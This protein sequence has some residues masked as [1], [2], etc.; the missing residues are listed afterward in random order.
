MTVVSQ[1]LAPLHDGIVARLSAQQPE[2][3]FHVSWGAAE[4]GT[5]RSLDEAIRLADQ[6]MYDTRRAEQA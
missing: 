3:R 4:F 2:L 6:A 5:K 1:R